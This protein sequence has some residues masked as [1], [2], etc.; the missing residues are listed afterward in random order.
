MTRSFVCRKPLP[1]FAGFS[2]DITALVV[3]LEEW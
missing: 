2:D 1:G 3:E